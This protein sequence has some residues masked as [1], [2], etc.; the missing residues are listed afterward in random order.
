[1][2][3]SLRNLGRVLCLDVCSIWHR[4]RVSLPLVDPASVPALPRVL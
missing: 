1:M 2:P 4:F 3:I